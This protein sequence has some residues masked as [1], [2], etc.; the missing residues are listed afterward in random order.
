MSLFHGYHII[1]LYR[2]KNYFS[3]FLACVSDSTVL[4]NTLLNII[5]IDC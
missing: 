5:I 2:C 3:G 1:L 4:L